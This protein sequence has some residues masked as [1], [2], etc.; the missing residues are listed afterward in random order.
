[1]DLIR[2]A[3]NLPTEDNP[4]DY[5]VKTSGRFIGDFDRKAPGR[6]PGYRRFCLRRGEHGWMV[7][8]VMSLWYTMTGKFQPTWIALGK[9]SKKARRHSIRRK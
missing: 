6:W 3:R 2:E 9:G 1:M 4:G 5:L 8:D 7:F